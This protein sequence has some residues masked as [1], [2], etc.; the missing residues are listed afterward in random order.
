[1]KVVIELDD[2]LYSF[3]KEKKLMVMDIGEVCNAIKYGI[4]LPKG[5]GNLI[6]SDTIDFDIKDFHSRGDWQV[7]TWGVQDAKVVIPA[8]KENKE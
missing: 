3:I 2:E 7:A 1:M 8:D 6:D 4:V 5:H